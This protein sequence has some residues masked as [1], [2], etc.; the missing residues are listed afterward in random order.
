MSKTNS[1]DFTRGPYQEILP[2]PLFTL[3]GVTE[4]D[5]EDIVAEMAGDLY[6]D[7]LDPSLY[8]E[9]ALVYLHQQNVLRVLAGEFAGDRDAG[10]LR[11]A[12]L[13]GEALSLRPFAQED[14]VYLTFAPVLQRIGDD[15]WR[16]GVETYGKTA[17]IGGDAPTALRR[18]PQI[19]V[20][21]AEAEGGA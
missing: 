11:D 6:R 16:L 1:S 21:W 3:S 15:S 20:S 13:R 17:V 4:D 9:D 14:V 5:L 8:Y 10:D 18:A 12:V 19:Y 2:P 7:L